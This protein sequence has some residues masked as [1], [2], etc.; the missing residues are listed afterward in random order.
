MKLWIYLLGVCSSLWASDPVLGTIT[1]IQCVNCTPGFIKVA[2]HDGIENKDFTVFVPETTYNKLLTPLPGKE[3][4]TKDQSCFYWM[5]SIP[6]SPKAKEVISKNKKKKH[7]TTAP[8]VAVEPIASNC[9]PYSL[10]PEK[11]LP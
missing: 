5:E 11:D 3:I 10:V 1:H 2:V 9:I 6:A 7:E 4:Y 8:I